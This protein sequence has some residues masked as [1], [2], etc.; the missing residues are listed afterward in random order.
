M[1]NCNFDRISKQNTMMKYVGQLMQSK[2]SN[3]DTL[4]DKCLVKGAFSLSVW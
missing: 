2:L 1:E 4:R 3:L